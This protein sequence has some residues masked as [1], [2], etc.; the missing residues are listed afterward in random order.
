M[1][2]AAAGTPRG[3]QFMGRPAVDKIEAPGVKA[4]RDAIVRFTDGGPKIG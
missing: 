1:V 2:A 4:I 3:G